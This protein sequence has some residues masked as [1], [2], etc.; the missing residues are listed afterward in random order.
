MIEKVSKS[1]MNIR[2]RQLGKGGYNFF[3]GLTAKIVPDVDI[4]NTDARTL[5]AGLAAASIRLRL[6]MLVKSCFAHIFIIALGA[7]LDER[8][9]GQ[10]GRKRPR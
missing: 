10:A 3:G 6:D 8:K 1:G 2:N 7:V 9:I 5:N 4:P